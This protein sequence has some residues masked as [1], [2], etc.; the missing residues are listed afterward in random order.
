[1]WIDAI[2]INREDNEAKSHQVRMMDWVCASASRTVV[3]L[4][5]ETSSSRTVFKDLSQAVDGPFKLFEDGIWRPERPSSDEGVVVGLEELIDRSW[6]SRIWVQ[7]EVYVSDGQS[8]LVVCGLDHAS[9]ELLH[10]CLFGYK[11]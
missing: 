6:F 3:Y 8:V 11:R 10:R 4:G 5:E 2:C 7:Q 1:M 9:W